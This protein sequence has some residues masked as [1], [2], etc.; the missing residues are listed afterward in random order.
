M[1]AGTPTP[2]GARP[3]HERAR[4]VA[5]ATAVLDLRDAR[6]EVAEAEDDL[7]AARETQA[8]MTRR[9]QDAAGAL[10]GNDR[11]WSYDCDKAEAILAETLL[12]F[13][14]HSAIVIREECRDLPALDVSPSRLA[15]LQGRR[16]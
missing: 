2:E 3:I 16:T 1:T 6:A 14:E 13:L 15:Q 7:K 8:A 11:G 12:G 9:R 4:I 10:L 5:Y